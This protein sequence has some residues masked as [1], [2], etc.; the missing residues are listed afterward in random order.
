VIV[1]HTG[2]TG[3]AIEEGSRNCNII[4]A[5]VFDAGCSGIRLGQVDDATLTD[6]SGFNMNL[7]LT[8]STLVEL[9][10]GYRDCS[11]IFGGFI[12]QS[13]IAHNLVTNSNWAGLTL[14]WGGW[15]GCGGVGRVV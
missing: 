5:S 7:S 4:K 12:S 13:T 14:G 6:P 1:K 11:A 10:Q 15:G 8:D 2:G 9:A 3:I